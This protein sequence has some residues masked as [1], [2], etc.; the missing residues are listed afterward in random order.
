MGPASTRLFI[1]RWPYLSKLLTVSILLPTSPTVRNGFID[2]TGRKTHRIYEFTYLISI[3]S[4]YSV[5]GAMLMVNK[6]TSVCVPWFM[7]PWKSLSPGTTSKSCIVLI[8]C[9]LTPDPGIITMGSFA[10]FPL[11]PLWDISPTKELYILH[12]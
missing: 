2:E 3:R 8:T 4:P 10:L 5:P 7:H 6:T 12:S 9:A 11:S 1:I